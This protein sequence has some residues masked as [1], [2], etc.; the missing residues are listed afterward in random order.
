MRCRASVVVVAG[1]MVWTMRGAHAQPAPSV[2]S[3]QP[4]S[5]APLGPTAPALRAPSATRDDLAMLE[6][7]IDGARYVLGP[8]DRLRLELWGLQELTQEIEVTADGKLVV[9]RA[10]MFDAGGTTL[11]ALR[12]AVGK[13]LHALYPRLESS[14]TLVAPRTF[15]VHVTGAVARPGSYPATPLERVSALLPDAGG[16]LPSGSLRRVEI[17]RRGV[18][19][20][21]I[22][23]LTKFAL[24]GQLDADPPLLDGDTVY[25]P[26]NKLSAEVTGG[27]RR[28][29]RYELV[30]GTLAELL[31]LAG[32]LAADAALSRPL[33]VSL[34]NDSDK[35]VVR[36]AAAGQASTVK[37]T[38]GALVHVPELGEV[39]PTIT[40][41]GAIRG[42]TADNTTLTSSLRAPPPP[43]PT[44]AP[45]TLDNR[46]DGAPR[47]VTVALPW[48]AGLGVRDV[49]GLAGGLQPWADA[50]H[51]YVS[52][53]AGNAEIARVSL[54]IWSITTGQRRDVPLEPGDRVVVPARREQIL[55]SGAV[56]K[57]GYYPYA[58]DLGP[59]DYLSMAGGPTRW[60]DAGGARVLQ[61]GV[62]RPIKKVTSVGPGDVI[63][64]PEHM[65]NAAEWTTISLVLGNIAVGAVAVG[66]AARR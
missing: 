65:F 17:R 2:S 42:L 33:R 3:S 48:V 19:Q 34:R 38:D 61:N 30:T 64:V 6:G 7:D 4:P 36:S 41:E 25:V 44:P 8:G 1:V 46:P 21:I 5:A 43:S 59:R 28:P 40:I 54:D 14:L 45:N 35:V 27:V 11:D 50:Q 55:V 12:A 66:L 26:A 52:R 31:E 60:G 53:R 10:G 63:T 57:P 9:P 15:M 39:Q 16:A 32:G 51:A 49:I 18:A 62:S 37:L 20:P 22:A 47:E 13:R 56:Q 24:L 29:G 23:D 58:S